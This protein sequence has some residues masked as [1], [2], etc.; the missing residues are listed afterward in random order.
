LTGR[1]V[2][3]VTRDP[4]LYGE[5]ALTLRDRHIPV[6]S[7][8]PGEPI[9]SRVKVVVTSPEECDQVRHRR[10]I[11]AYPG[12]RAALLAAIEDAYHEGPRGG[13]LVGIDPGP[14]PGFAVVRSDGTCLVQGVIESPEAVVRLYRSLRYFFAEPLLLFRVGNGDAIRR[15]RILNALLSNHVPVEMVNERRTT[16]PGRRQSDLLAAVA[17]AATPGRRV[18]HQEPLRITRGDVA[19]LQSLS[20]RHSNGRYTISRRL[21]RT[22]LAGEISLAEALDLTASRQARGDEPHPPGLRRASRGT[23][24]NPETGRPSAS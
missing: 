24:P 5:L 7:L 19:H 17:I 12:D 2:A 20:R 13:I 23:P 21:A 8:F 22:V 11:P 6:L 18:S 14:R 15:D 1:A 16:P 3:V 10:V 4:K 9:P